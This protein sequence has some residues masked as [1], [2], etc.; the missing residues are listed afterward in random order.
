MSDLV[1]D[2]MVETA[3]A[4]QWNYDW[5]HREFRRE[6]DD[7]QDFYRNSARAGLE[8]VA[9][10]IAAKALEDAAEALA[11]LPSA[12]VGYGRYDSIGARK[13]RARQYERGVIGHWLK[14]RADRIEHDARCPHRKCQGG[15]LCCCP[16]VES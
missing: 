11:A 15:S 12:A 13:G 7:L 8:A 4:A 14:I 10:L 3:A 16:A 1:T 6:P 5:P 2:A 9:T